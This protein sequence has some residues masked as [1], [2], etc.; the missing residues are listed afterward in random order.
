VCGGLCAC[1]ILSAAASA[2]ARETSG[3]KISYASGPEVLAMFVKRA[4]IDYP[5]MARSQYRT[6]TGIFRM[7]INPDGTV[8]TVGVLKSTSHPDLDLAAAAGLYHCLFKPGR[9]RELDLP[10][11]FTMS[12]GR[13]GWNR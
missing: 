11:M 2:T 12:R 4:R 6:G 9:R 8:R 7:Y 10:V 5:W 1:L 13:G 3:A